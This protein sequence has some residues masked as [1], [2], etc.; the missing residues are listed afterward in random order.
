M[1]AR[2]LWI[3]VAIV[4]LAPLTL[5]HAQSYYWAPGPTCYITIADTETLASTVCWNN[6]SPTSPSIPGY[7]PPTAGSYVFLIGVQDNILL[8]IDSTGAPSTLH[9]LTIDDTATQGLITFESLSPVAVTGTEVVG[10]NGEAGIFM[11]GSTHSVGSLIVGQNVGSAGN[12]SIRGGTFTAGSVTVGSN[13]FGFMQQNQSLGATTV[14]VNGTLVIA[15]G[16]SSS[17]S[18]YE[19]DAGT[20]TTTADT[21]VGVNARGGF[22]LNGG[23]HNVFGS[24]MLAQNPGSEGDYQL[25]SGT[26]NVSGDI[27]G[28]AGTSL[29]DIRG[30]T[31][32]IGGNVSNVTFLDLASNPG[33]NGSFSV[34]GSQSVS[35]QNEL[36]GDEGAG[37]FTQSGGSNSA[38]TLALG[39]IQG[40]TGTYNLTG[41]TLNAAF[42]QVG[43]NGQGTF[44]QSGNSSVVVGTEFDVGVFSG[45]SGAYTLS[46]GTLAAPIELIGQSAPMAAPA[47]FT[48]MGGSNSTG[49][50]QLG[51][52]GVYQ[53]LGGELDVSSNIIGN[54]QLE[55]G[56]G[57]LN[58]G[59][60]VDVGTLLLDSGTAFEVGNE[61]SVSSTT[62]PSLIAGA[63]TIDNTASVNIYGN[64]GITGAGGHTSSGS[65]SIGSPFSPA[66]AE[67]IVTDSAQLV[68]N[69]YMQF[70]GTG[71]LAVQSGTFTNAA[72]GNVVMT[73]QSV[74]S[75]VVD[76]SG[77][78]DNKGTVSQFSGDVGLSV[79]DVTLSPSITNEGSWTLNAPAT[80]TVLSGQFTNTTNASF[81]NSGGAVTIGNGGSFVNAGQFFNNGTVQIQAGGTVASDGSFFNSGTVR[82]DP[83]AAM[84]GAGTYTQTGGL[85]K[86]NGTLSM[87]TILN[88]GGSFGGT[89]TINGSA[90]DPLD[91]PTNFY[92][93]GGTIAPGDPSELTI[94]GN[95]FFSSGL[96]DIKIAGVNDLDQI[97]VTGLAQIT[98]GTLE[99]DF[100]NG[101]APHKGDVYEF[102][103][104]NDVGAAL[105]ASVVITGL[106]PG[107]QYALTPGADGSFDLTAE[108]DG[109]SAVPL[110]PALWLLASGALLVLL[111]GRRRVPL[112]E[113]RSKLATC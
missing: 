40:G 5:A 76:G 6:T 41:G 81:N 89:G 64:A 17:N 22:N 12:V 7:G 100:T 2:C 33:D 95:L 38:S 13:G 75:I 16:A 36:I 37:L 57:T 71:T 99:L 106:A 107:F 50:I 18:E 102:L 55:L 92:N 86:V 63:L 113:G 43:V 24:L 112:P 70:T 80:L 88:Q 32:S 1:R 66:P 101:F 4:S 79:S 69:G 14:T 59:G 87:A 29:L 11:S 49:A 85:T 105:F 104:G 19:V 65:L 103:V 53:L 61:L 30:G 25:I 98:G 84:S 68:N 21:V 27:V 23:T 44:N 72:N 35:V 77:V 110:P 42:V 46:G 108:S 3:I 94:D 48:Q 20:L 10:Q 83:G 8:S 109:V 31:I 78:F 47:A 111:I 60:T 52:Q 93:L 28:G 82:I 15:D 39:E 73:D 91:N 51:D 90:I 62:V 97:D 9:S 96:L 34:G 56:G 67:L 74:A 45:S 54:G 26:L 58:V